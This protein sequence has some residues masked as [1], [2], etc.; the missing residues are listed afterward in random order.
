[1]RVAERDGLFA[2]AGLRVDLVRAA[3]AAERDQLL[4]AGRID[5][6]VTDPVAVVLYAAGGMAVR[7]VRHSMVPTAGHPQFR[8]VAGPG[9]GVRQARDL[10]G[11]PVATS[12]G[13]IAEYAGR[14]T[15]AAAGLTDDEIRIVAVPALATRLALLADG[16]VAA[17]VLPEPFATQAI[18]TGGIAID[19]GIDQR[20]FCCSVIAFREAVLTERRPEV[21]RFL[22][23]LDAAALTV[24]ADKPAAVRYAVESMVLPA[25]CAD[26]I[27]LADY[28]VGTVPDRA[29]FD[30]VT[31]WLS[32]TGRLSRVPSYDGMVCPIGV[33]SR[34]V[35]RP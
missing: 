14:R 20:P 8:V 26:A 21:D 35:A 24:N 12:E 11:V 15:L 31:A 10:R 9:S 19:E 17:A 5:G 22:A 34:A 28:P 13:T 2:G 6:M 1:M 4:Q 18:V 33:S 16:K 29:L 3:S 32:H 7:A 25:G 27:V 23:A 30:G